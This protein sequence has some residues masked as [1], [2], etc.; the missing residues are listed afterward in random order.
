M[1]LAVGSWQLAVGSWQL[2]VGS[3]QNGW[4]ELKWQTGNKQMV[5]FIKKFVLKEEVNHSRFAYCALL[6]PICFDARK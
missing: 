1:Q 3:W 5:S 4:A 6:L 2:A